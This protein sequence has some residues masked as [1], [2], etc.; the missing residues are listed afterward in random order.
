MPEFLK[1]PFLVL[2][3]SYYKL[4]YIND[5][6]GNVIGNNSIYADDNI[7]YSNCYKA[8]DLW[9]K[10]ELAAELESDLRD[11]VDWSRK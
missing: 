1:A 2:H 10:L 5:L 6:P 8:S 11:T 3:F 9:Q 4:I 7:L